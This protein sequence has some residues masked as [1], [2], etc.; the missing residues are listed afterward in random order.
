MNNEHR[1]M[2]I[3]CATIIICVALMS[4]CTQSTGVF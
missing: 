1:T 2:L 3:I 4:Q